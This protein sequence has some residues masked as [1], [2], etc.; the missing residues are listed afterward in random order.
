MGESNGHVIAVVSEQRLV[1]HIS[2]ALNTY[3]HRAGEGSSREETGQERRAEER[4]GKD[5]L[6]RIMDE[7]TSRIAI[8]GLFPQ[9]Q[10]ITGFECT[11]SLP[12]DDEAFLKLN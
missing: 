9:R 12:S 6:T 11:C 2:A 4:R 10:G 5:G 1:S 7:D 8:L 3:A